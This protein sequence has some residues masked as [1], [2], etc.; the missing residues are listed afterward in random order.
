[1]I[2]IEVAKQVEQAKLQVSKDTPIFSIL[3]PVVVPNEKSGPKRIL[4]IALW[5][6]LGFVFGAGKSLF[7]DQIKKFILKVRS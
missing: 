4:I 3:K 7:Q 2:F 5:V 6:F 1:M